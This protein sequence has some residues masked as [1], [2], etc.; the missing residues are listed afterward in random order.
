MAEK[1]KYGY[2]YSGRD[3]KKKGRMTL[4]EFETMD[5]GVLNTVDK[6][7]EGLNIPDIRV[8]VFLGLNSSKTKRTQ[9]VGRAIRTKEG[10]V[11]EIF[12]LVIKNSVEVKWFENSCTSQNYIT[13]DE[14]QLDNVLN[15]ESFTPKKNKQTSL[16]F[17]F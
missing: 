5:N 17:R 11:A 15:Y 7:N 16:K 2:C 9:R 14:E 13:I 8:A 6:V 3:S 10:K 1:I 12:Y 4:A